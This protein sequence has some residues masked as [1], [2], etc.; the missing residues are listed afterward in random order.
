MRRAAALALGSALIHAAPAFPVFPFRIPNGTLARCANCHTNPAGGGPRNSFGQDFAASGFTW[1]LDLAQIDSDGDGFS[2]GLELQDVSAEWTSGSTPPGD[3]RMVSV[4]G[5]ASSTPGERGIVLSEVLLRGASSEQRIELHNRLDVAVDAAGLYLFTGDSGWV[6]PSGQPANTTI[7]PRGELVVTVNGTAPNAPGRLSESPSGGIASLG[8]A[9]YI[10]LA[11]TQDQGG[12]FNLPQILTDFVQW[13]QP[14]QER[15]AIAVNAGQWSG[16]GA[17]AV[18][19]GGTTIEFDG[20]GESALDWTADAPATLGSANVN[21]IVLGL[22]GLHP[23]DLAEVRDPD[24]NGDGVI[25]AAD[26]VARFNQVLP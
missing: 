22:L 5:R 17:V 12:A 3:E 18:P 10:L 21:H 16:G 25:S 23:L 15:E 9:D 2:N 14:A 7:P 26:I 11:W 4:P 20:V 24:A 13:G 19:A 8:T 1:T 6:I